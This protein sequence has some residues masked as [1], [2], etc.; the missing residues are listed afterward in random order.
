MLRKFVKFNRDSLEGRYLLGMSY[1]NTNEFSQGVEQLLETLTI[2]PLFKKS[3]YLVIALA[4][5]KLGKI[6]QAI[7]IVPHSLFSC[8]RACSTLKTITT[9]LYTEGKCT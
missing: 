4:F 2:D 8:L 9:A 5:K 3:L 1:I 7:Q 6:D